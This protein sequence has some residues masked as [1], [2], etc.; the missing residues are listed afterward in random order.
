MIIDVHTHHYLRRETV[1]TTQPIA[2]VVALAKQAGI[3]RINLL[4]NLARNG[5]ILRPPA[6]DV[7]GK[8]PTVEASFPTIWSA[9]GTAPRLRTHSRSTVFKRSSMTSGLSR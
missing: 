2:P 4:G 3:T 6:R 1:K 7:R 8:P 9:R 5:N